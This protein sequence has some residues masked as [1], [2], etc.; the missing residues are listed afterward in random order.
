MPVIL[1]DQFDRPI[2][3]EKKPRSGRT[4]HSTLYDRWSD[5]PADSL[6]PAKFASILKMAE[7]GD[8]KQQAEAF[9]TME[10]R[11]TDLS[12]YL[13]TRKLAVTGLDWEIRV[14]AKDEAL[15]TKA[16]ELQ[17]FLTDA[18]NYLVGFNDNLYDML[19][20]IGKGYSATEIIW[21]ERDS[22]NVPED[23]V[24]IHPKRAI[25][26]GYGKSM[27]P[28]DKTSEMPNI[29]TGANDMF[30][31]PPDPRKVIY[32]RHKAR[33]GYDTRAGLIRVCGWMYV[34][35][36]FD[37]KTWLQF[38]EVFGMPLILGKYDK[39][40]TPPSEVENLIEQIAA[41]GTHA[42]GAVPKDVDI[43]IV[44]AS[45][46]SSVDLYERLA[47]FCNKSMA[48]CIL[49]QTATAEGT[50]GKLGNEDAQENVRRDL[51]EHDARSLGE[52]IDYQLLRPLTGFNYGWEILSKLRPRFL[53]KMKVSED[54]QAMSQI[55]NTLMAAGQPVSQEHISTRFKIPL[56]VEGETPVVRPEPAGYF[57]G[58]SYPG[59]SQPQ[60]GVPQP[61]GANSQIEGMSLNGAQIMAAA[62][63]ME[64]L[65][66]KLIAK[67]VAVGLLIALGIDESTAIKMVNAQSKLTA[68]LVP[69]SAMSRPVR[70]GALNNRRVIA[71][72]NPQQMQLET[73]VFKSNAAAKK[74]FKKM[75]A[76]LREIVMSSKSFPEMRDRILKAYKELPTRDL[77]EIIAQTLFVARLYGN[78]T[79]QEEQRHGE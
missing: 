63:I 28:D 54:M 21:G 47:T 32:H 14:D 25:F 42:S 2:V 41:I 43:Q 55:Y 64:K 19:D 33:S 78:A 15:K 50:P 69:V 12:S 60:D 22:F 44:E 31:V 17:S 56:P 23:L 76:P 13:N 26:Y 8:V 38:A 1:Y 24:W 36:N 72:V 11:D 57:P 62:D 4:F 40:L 3:T 20:A 53:F 46:N 65:I 51:T 27:S 18:L 68:P 74:A 5:H 59:E 61:I 58:L 71:N 45:K 73:L 34:F 52:T 48:K 16:E 6:T 35:K 7:L 30:G 75:A 39:D 9:E 37:I 70:Y 29:R 79:I 10:E 66:N 49:G 67:E 77:E